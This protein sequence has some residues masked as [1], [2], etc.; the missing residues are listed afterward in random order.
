[1]TIS[2]KCSPPTESTPAEFGGQTDLA[3]CRRR[4]DS[5]FSLHGRSPGS[6]QY[7]GLS[8]GD[9]PRHPQCRRGAS[10]DACARWSSPT[11]AGTREW[12]VIHHTD[13]GMESSPT[14]GYGGC[15]RTASR[16]RAR[17]RTFLRRRARGPVRPRRNTWT[18]AHDQ[19]RRE[20]RDRGRSRIPCHT[21]RPGRASRLRYLYDVKTGRLARCPTRRRPVPPPEALQPR[22][23]I[24]QLLRSQAA[25][26]CTIG[27]W[28]ISW[29]GRPDGGL[30]S[31]GPPA[32]Y[33]TES[34]H[35]RAVRGDQELLEVPLDVTAGTLGVA[36]RRERRAR[37]GRGP[38]R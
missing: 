5:R 12:F 23:A 37:S 34:A 2:R 6:A 20:E 3:P 27:W 33:G 1:M 8:E 7:A 10:D 22:L 31:P 24:V 16:P 25:E 21:R 4:A 13:C 29:G 35:H 36:D 18:A 32:R 30:G 11:A 17:V 15:W 38:G 19:R 9:A 26:S 14:R 28:S